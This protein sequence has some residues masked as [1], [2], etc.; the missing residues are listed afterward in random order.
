MNRPVDK[1]LSAI[2]LSNDVCL[3]FIDVENMA[4]S[5][6]LTVEGVAS[7][8]KSYVSQAHAKPSDLFFVAAGPQNATA[9]REGWKA[10]QTFYQFRKGKDGADLALVNFYQSIEHV[11]AFKEIFVASGDHSLEPIAESSVR[12]GVP[13]TVVTG[14][15]RRS[16]VFSLYSQLSVRGF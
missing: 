7:L 6:L 4:G 9:V 8:C 2:S 14:K 10:G 12:R 15:G 13:V 5:G 3:H 1:L 11:E 16:R